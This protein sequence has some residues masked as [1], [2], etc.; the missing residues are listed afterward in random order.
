VDAIKRYQ[1]A[2]KVDLTTAAGVIDALSKP[3]Q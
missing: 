1:D 3:S 2:A